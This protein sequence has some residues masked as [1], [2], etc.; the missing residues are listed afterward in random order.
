MIG[1]LCNDSDKT[2][3]F[4]YL[5]ALKGRVSLDIAD[6]YNRGVEIGRKEEREK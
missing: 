1:R 3:L 5:Y 6:A 4:A 2:G